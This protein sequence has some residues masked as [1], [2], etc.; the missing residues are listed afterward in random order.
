MAHDAS[1]RSAP[2][3]ISIGHHKYGA[4]PHEKPPKFVNQV[5]ALEFMWKM[6]N[7]KDILKQIWDVLERGATAWAVAR[8]ILYKAILEGYVLMPLAMLMMPKVQSMI[9]VIGKSKKINVKS[10]PKFRD[11]TVDSKIKQHIDQKLG[12]QTPAPLPRSALKQYLM[13]KAEDITKAHESFMKS[14]GPNPGLLDQL[15]NQQQVGE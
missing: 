9:V 11:K 3:G 1:F 14:K 8:A 13:P 12:R 10:M 7:R 6:L 4:L 2:P 15:K 5:E